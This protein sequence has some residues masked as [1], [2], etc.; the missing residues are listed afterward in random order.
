MTKRLINFNSIWVNSRN[1]ILQ[2]ADSPLRKVRSCSVFQ[3]WDLSDEKQMDIE[4]LLSCMLLFLGESQQRIRG[5]GTATWP[6]EIENNILSSV[7]ETQGCIACF[8]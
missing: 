7:F 5:A 1:K 2:V 4:I 6:L 3:P 8:S